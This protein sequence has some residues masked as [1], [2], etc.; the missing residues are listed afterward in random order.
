MTGQ[1]IKLSTPQDHN[2]VTKPYIHLDSRFP[3]VES[4][5]MYDQETAK[6]L[7]A[8]GQTLM[9]RTGRGLTV[10]EREL[11]A[12]FV[13]KLNDC[14]FCFRSHAQAA[15]LLFGE[16]A[17]R[18]LFAEEDHDLPARLRALLVVAVCVQGLDREELPAAIDDAR[19][20]GATEEEVHDTVL[21]TSF[22]CMVN[23]YVDGLG[24][25]FEPG[26]PEISG[27]NL[28]KFGY[29]MSARRFFTEVLPKMWSHF[30]A[31]VWG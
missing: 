27:T 10:S 31:E 21:I 20:F 16:Q 13:S 19:L 6:H 3:G 9:R 22:I 28:V 30:W 26:E 12:A 25:T 15:K 2:D 7:S 18:F 17:S 1:S 8:L 23:R 4:L 24:T 11:V 14:S 29:V 5:L